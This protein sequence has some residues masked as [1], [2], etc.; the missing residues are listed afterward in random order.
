MEVEPGFHKNLNELAQSE[1]MVNH[2]STKLFK[3][4]ILRIQIKRI[5]LNVNQPKARRKDRKPKSSSV[6]LVL[7]SNHHEFVVNW[8]FSGSNKKT[9]SEGYKVKM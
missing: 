4:E 3:D 6:S 9:S 7:T 1:L 2:G 8:D 5:K